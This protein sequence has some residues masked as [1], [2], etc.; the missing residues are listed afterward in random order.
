MGECFHGLY[1][2]LSK[3][4]RGGSIIVVVDR[5]SKYETGGSIIVVVD[6]FSKYGT[7]IAVPPDVTADDTAKLFFKNMSPATLQKPEGKARTSGFGCEAIR[8]TVGSED[9]ASGT[10]EQN[11]TD[12]SSF[13]FGDQVQVK[14]CLNNSKSLKEGRPRRGVSKQAPIAVVTS[15]D[16][17]VEDILSDHTIRRRGVP[18]YKEHLIKWHDLPD[19][20]VSWEAKDLLWQF[21]ARSRISREGTTR[22]ERSLEALEARGMLPGRP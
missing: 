4:K 10:D 2:M 19:S 5:F 6:R 11:E 20:E 12:T 15:Y 18:S 17:E 13:E 8:S 3:V 14:L 21:A 22:T 9:E 7:F 1:H 16:R